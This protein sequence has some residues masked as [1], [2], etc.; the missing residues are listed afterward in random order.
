MTA[1]QI[2][3]ELAQTLESEAASRGLTIEDFL[4]SVLWRER[5]LADRR[6]IEQEQEWWLNRPLSH[7]AKYEGQHIAVHE[8]QLIDHDA[9]ENALFKRIRAKYGN[10]PI[11]IMPA[12]GPR[13]IR[14]FSPRLIQR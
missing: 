9:D 3:D 12:E 8:K 11:L 13:E 2:S 14:I 5:T 4:R 7:R 1:L 6:K 10:T